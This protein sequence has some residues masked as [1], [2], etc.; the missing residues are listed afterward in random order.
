MMLIIFSAWA[1]I[2]SFEYFSLKVFNALTEKKSQFLKIFDIIFDKSFFLVKSTI[3]PFFPLTIISFAPSVFVQITGVPSLK[4]S[5]FT[6][7]K[8]SDLLADMLAKHFEKIVPI[9]LFGMFPKKAT[10]LFCFNDLVNF[11]KVF[12]SGPSPT[13]KSF[14]FG[15]IFIHSLNS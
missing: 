9:S 12:F 7:P 5:M 4:D 11:F 13:I 10:W 1:E 15:T 14:S 3:N 8:A 2:F 6:I